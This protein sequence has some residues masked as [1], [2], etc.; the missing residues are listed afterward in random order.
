MEP[1]QNKPSGLQIYPQ[2]RE[3]LPLKILLVEDIA[4][5]Q[6]VAL[7]MLQ[8]LGY[9]ADVAKNGQEALEALASCAY[10]LIFM[11]VQMPVMDGLEATRQIRQSKTLS[12][13]WIVAMTAHSMQGDRE[14]CLAAGMDDY[15]SKPISMEALGTAFV[16]V[17]EWL[18]GR[19]QN[20]SNL[21]GLCS[22]VENAGEVSL[23]FP[24][25]PTN[26]SSFFLKHKFLPTVDLSILERLKQ[27][28]EGDEGLLTEIIE[29]YLEDAKERVETVAIAVTQKDAVALY[30]TSHALRSLSSSVGAAYLSCLCEH[31]E[32]KAQE[33]DLGDTRSLLD[34]IQVEFKQV[35]AALFPYSLR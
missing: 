30:R 29:S 4:V 15:I 32:R 27:I 19:Q 9:S 35:M 8:R 12:S 28:A 14:R 21:T 16:R 22:E 3:K 26:P 5:N 24:S 17:G 2:L 25:E 20:F 1:P 13:P 34:A 18:E 11:D 23:H 6:K 33:N 31:L 10:D 7:R